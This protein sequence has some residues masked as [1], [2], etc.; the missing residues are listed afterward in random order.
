M[1]GRLERPCMYGQMLYIICYHSL[2][3]KVNVKSQ[4]G[5]SA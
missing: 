2:A 3:P 4:G 5:I 1:L